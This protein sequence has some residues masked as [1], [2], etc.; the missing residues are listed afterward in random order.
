MDE[1]VNQVPMENQQPEVKGQQP[2]PAPEA[3]VK[4]EP[5]PSRVRRREKAQASPA[6][7]LA[8]ESSDEMGKSK[9]ASTVTLRFDERGQP[10]KAEPETVGRAR[11]WL[12]LAGVVEA[13]PEPPGLV[14][15]P[16]LDEQL[17]EHLLDGLSYLQ[18]GLVHAF[19]GLS[20]N[21]VLELARLKR[22]EQA[23]L[24]PLT[25]R[26][27]Q[28][29]VPQL[30]RFGGDMA[31]LVIRMGTVEANKVV[32]VQHKLKKERKES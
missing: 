7:K 20:F 15:E 19:T 25:A 18:A 23:E 28:K 29:Y 16:A 11:E 5:P 17:A 26:V 31:G 8:P 13:E 22:E 9:S 3:E 14:P 4:I 24:V 27:L 2:S 6:P 12:R 32:A 30:W 21:E 1:N 10:L